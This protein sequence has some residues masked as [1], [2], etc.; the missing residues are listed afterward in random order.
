MTRETA[1]TKEIAYDT[2]KCQICDTEVALNDSMNSE[3][4]EPQGYAVILGTGD[5]EKEREHQGNWDVT[6]TFEQD[7]ENDQLPEVSGY[8]V[9]E[10]CGDS[11]HNYSPER[12]WYTGSIP[13]T[14]DS[15]SSALLRADQETIIW[16]VIGLVV[17]FGFLLMLL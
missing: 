6:L 4:H 9:C 7:S 15:E 17:F 2:Q 1:V 14:L 3:I 13:D 12:E 5:L 8:I 10:D 16:V 11:F